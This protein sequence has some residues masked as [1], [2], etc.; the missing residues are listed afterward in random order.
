VGAVRKEIGKRNSL[1]AEDGMRS[2]GTLSLARL[3]D[4]WQGHEYDVV[5][6][7]S[8]NA[9]RSWI[10]TPTVLHNLFMRYFYRMIL[11]VGKWR[12]LLGVDS[13]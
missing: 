8:D 1:Q 13:S 2:V 7:I 9:F 10:M 3:Y 12:A 6:L 5:M 11:L 4:G